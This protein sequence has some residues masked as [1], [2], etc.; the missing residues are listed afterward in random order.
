MN[1]TN[2]LV[3]IYILGIIIGGFVGLW[4]KETSFKPLIAM[5]WTAFFLVALLYA[6]KKDN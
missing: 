2:I 6:G 3:I 1:K 4:D 5:L